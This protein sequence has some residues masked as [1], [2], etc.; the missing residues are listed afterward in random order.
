METYLAA[1]FGGLAS[2]LLGIAVSQLRSQGK[3]QSEQGRQLVRIE[4]VLT[5]ADGTNGVTG[6]HPG[7]RGDR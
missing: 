6:L 4:T 7:G 3:T 1:G 5:G 2:V